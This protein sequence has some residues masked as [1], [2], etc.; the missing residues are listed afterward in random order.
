MIELLFTPGI[1]A[2]HSAR[3]GES[4]LGEL[5]KYNQNIKLSKIVFGRLGSESYIHHH[6]I[7]YLIT[8]ELNWFDC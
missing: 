2:H 5:I 3:V 1:G 8:L 4:S 6:Q 7:P